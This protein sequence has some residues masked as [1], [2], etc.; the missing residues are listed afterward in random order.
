LV[1]SKDR[2]GPYVRKGN[3][4]HIGDIVLDIYDE[5]IY[6]AGTAFGGYALT[7]SVVSAKANVCTSINTYIH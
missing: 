7:T 4:Y 1:I 2:V 3:P 5:V 6:T